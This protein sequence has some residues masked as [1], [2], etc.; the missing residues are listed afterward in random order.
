[1]F[2]LING[3]PINV[4]ALIYRRTPCY[5]VCVYITATLTVWGT[6]IER[7]KW[8]REGCL[9]EINN[10]PLHREAPCP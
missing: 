5:V 3:S 2:V 4:V 8:M 1:M 10:P 9:E 6:G 7:P